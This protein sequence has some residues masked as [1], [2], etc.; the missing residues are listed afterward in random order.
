[1]ILDPFCG[2]GS[3]IAA[4]NA[5]GYDSLGVEMDEIYFSN[6]EKNIKAFSSLYPTYKGETI[7]TPPD[8]LPLKVRKN[9]RQGGLA[10]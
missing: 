1:M 6:L 3:T 10:L 7:D 4:C 2:S 9:D 5:V 8:L